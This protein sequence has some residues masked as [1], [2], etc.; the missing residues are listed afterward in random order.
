MTTLSHED[1]Q[2]AELR[3]AC[4]S[5][6]GALIVKLAHV[7][8]NPNHALLLNAALLRKVWDDLEPLVD[9]HAR[10]DPDLELAGV[11]WTEMRA[12]IP[13]LLDESLDCARRIQKVVATLR[14]KVDEPNSQGRD[15][16]LPGR[17]IDS[18]T[19]GLCH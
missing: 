13:R 8:N 11:P 14:D 9:E 18:V 15:P 4:G 2:I 12:V 16:D 1:T 7:I 3:E 10:N 6:E 17:D 19:P 5:A